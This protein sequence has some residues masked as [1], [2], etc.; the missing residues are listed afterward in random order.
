MIDFLV[1]VNANY[2]KEIQTLHILIK[3]VFIY[4]FNEFF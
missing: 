3:K 4:L 2:A 1:K